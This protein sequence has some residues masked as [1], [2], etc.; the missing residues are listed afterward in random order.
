MRSTYIPVDESTP[1]PRRV[2][3]LD[4]K[5]VGP[6]ARLG[7]FMA[8][9]T[10]DIF[11]IAIT[12]TLLWL[13]AG[14]TV[15]SG[16]PLLMSV[17]FAVGVMLAGGAAVLRPR[18]VRSTVVTSIIFVVVLV[19]LWIGTLADL[20]GYFLEWMTLYAAMQV[21]AGAVIA[22]A[23]QVFSGGGRGGVVA[24]VCVLVTSAIVVLLLSRVWSD[25]ALLGDLVVFT[26]LLA[27]GARVLDA[28]I[29]FFRKAGG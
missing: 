19:S 4:K 28:A 3:D 26:V 11:S 8:A 16:E 9:M 15:L 21:G 5:V 29:R 27:A 18:T 7:L 23:L 13:G 6:A 2:E 12:P 14:A 20:G 10:L 25:S 22:L 17:A 1:G 24:L